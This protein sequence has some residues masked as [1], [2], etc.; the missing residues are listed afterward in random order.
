M[1]NV[2]DQIKAILERQAREDVPESLRD[3]LHRDLETI[4]SLVRCGLRFGT[5]ASLDSTESLEKEA[6]FILRNWIKKK[7]DIVSFIEGYLRDGAMLA[8]GDG[9]KKNVRQVGKRQRKRLAEATD[10]Q[11]MAIAHRSDIIEGGDNFEERLEHLKLTREL[12][13]KDG[14]GSEEKQDLFRKLQRPF[15]K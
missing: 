9:R 2:D 15:Q 8:F 5:G 4:V 10:D 3:S 13:Q 11:L 6:A 12:F 14:S 7:L 1:S